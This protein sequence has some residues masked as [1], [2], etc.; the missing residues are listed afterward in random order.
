MVLKT[1]WRISWQ[2]LDGF[3]SEYIVKKIEKHWQHEK[4]SKKRTTSQC[5][6]RWQRWFCQWIDLSQEG[7]PKSHRTTR[8]ISRETG[9]HH[10]SVYHIVRQNLRL[11][12][13]KK[14]SA[15]ELTVANSAS[16]QTHARKLLC[17]FLASAVDFIFFTDE[18]IFSV[19]PPVNLQ[20]DHMHVPMNAKKCEV[21]ADRLFCS[22]PTFR[23]SIM[24]SVTVSKL[25]CSG[26][27]FVEPGTKVG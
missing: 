20:N 23:K 1:Y 21:A 6:R 26:L 7:A 9:I 11:K 16:C 14:H 5:A 10:S 15:Q 24:V 13:L 8:Q 12:W 4:A 25:G 2:R 19:A 18:K 17:R 22:R 3:W 27:M